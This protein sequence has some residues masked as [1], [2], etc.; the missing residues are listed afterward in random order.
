M[1]RGMTVM[2]TMMMNRIEILITNMSIPPKP[3]TPSLAERCL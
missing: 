3:S 1:D 2:L